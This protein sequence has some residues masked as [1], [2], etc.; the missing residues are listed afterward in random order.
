MD[1]ALSEISPAWR[2]LAPDPLKAPKGLFPQ[3]P[4]GGASVF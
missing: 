4:T 2:P 3:P 1:V